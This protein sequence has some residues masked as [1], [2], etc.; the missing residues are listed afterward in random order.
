MQRMLGFAASLPGFATLPLARAMDGDLDELNQGDAAGICRF[1]D[2]R[3]GAEGK[4]ILRRRSPG[5]HGGS[6]YR[7]VRKH[8]MPPTIAGVGK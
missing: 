6:A 8:K 7:P 5:D 1:H 4:V 3:G 2:T